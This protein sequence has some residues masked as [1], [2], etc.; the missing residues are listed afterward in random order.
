MA[1][2]RETELYK[3]LYMAFLQQQTLYIRMGALV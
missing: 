3:V 2:P 1:G